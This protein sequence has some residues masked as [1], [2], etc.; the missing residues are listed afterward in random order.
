[1]MA[2]SRRL[3]EPGKLGLPVALVLLAFCLL[4]SLGCSS[5][6]LAVSGSGDPGP[7]AEPRELAAHG[8]LSLS[9]S[10]VP[11]PDLTDGL[12]VGE[13]V[14]LSLARSWD[15]RAQEA[16]RHEAEGEAESAS[17]WSNPELR[18]QRLEILRPFGSDEDDKERPWYDG[19]DLSIRWRLPRPG[20]D[21]GRAEGARHRAEAEASTSLRSRQELAARVRIL[22]FRI[23]R[24]DARIELGEEELKLRRALMEMVERQLGSG[25]ATGLD[26]SLAE[27]DHWEARAVQ[28]RRQERRNDLW[29]E[30]SSLTGLDPATGMKLG[31]PVDAAPCSM[32]DLDVSSLVE[33]AMARR[34]DLLA[35]QQRLAEAEARLQAAYWSRLPWPR[36]T[37]LSYRFDESRS[38]DWI[39]L[40]LA[41]DLPLLDWK[42]GE[43][44]A[45]RARRA[46]RKAML[47]AGR[48]QVE[49][50]V[51]QALASLRSRG[52]ILA[53]FEQARPAIDASLSQMKKAIEAGQADL[54]E[55]VSVK[56]REMRLSR[57]W[58][59][60]RM[61]CHMART[62]LNLALGK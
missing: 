9:P 62:A 50:A 53:T 36:F 10:Q 28:E 12:S 21:S 26:R 15:L 41:L 56:E 38:G 40:G 23:V 37:E 5:A 52:K 61:G 6:P 60:A 20:V 48:V 8:A 43:I 35:L 39:H 27:L 29:L 33:Q 4:A 44:A 13:A 16:R 45:L 30:L 24:F 11:A 57:A 7:L 19:L 46:R 51:R 55:L 18:S 47:E 42:G 54:L 25:S 59:D 1:M 32:V 14:S 22:F 3:A 2:G 49:R 58:I 34:P 31:P 17:T